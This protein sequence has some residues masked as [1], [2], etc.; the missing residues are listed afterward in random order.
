MVVSKIENRSSFRHINFHHNIGLLNKVFLVIKKWWPFFTSLI[1]K[2]MFEEASYK[3]FVALFFVVHH[4]HALYINMMLW[5]D[6]LFICNIFQ[7]YGS[8]LH[9]TIYCGSLIRFTYCG[10]LLK[11]TLF[12]VLFFFSHPVRHCT[13]NMKLG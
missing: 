6:S 3:S 13:F 7:T 5:L 1:P 11:W 8:L 12:R 2:L 10:G 4:P 9:G